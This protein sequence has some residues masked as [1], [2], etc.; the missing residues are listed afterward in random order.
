[1]YGLIRKYVLFDNREGLTV[2]G[3]DILMAVIEIPI[4]KSTIIDNIVRECQNALSG[5]ALYEAAV[6]AGLNTM[7]DK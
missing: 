4:V 5:Q 2:Q 7:D 1:M 6:N 3:K